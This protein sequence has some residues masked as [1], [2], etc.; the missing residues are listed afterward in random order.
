MADEPVN[1]YTKVPKH[2]LHEPENPNIELHQIKLPFRCCVVAP[3]GA[4]KTNWLINLVKLFCE[5]KGTFSSVF[6]LTRN[7]DEPLYNFLKSK[8]DS[9]Q[10][11]EG[12]HHLPPLDKFDKK[13][14]H[15]VVLDDLVLDDQKSVEKYYIRCRKLNVSIIFISQSYFRISKLIRS[16][17]SY[18]VI[19][20]LSGDRDCRL[21]LSEMSLGLSK[22]QLMA[23]YKHATAKKF[24]C[25]FIDCEAD[26][27]HRFRHNFLTVLDPSQ[28]ARET[29]G[30]KPKAALPAPAENVVL[31]IREHPAPPKSLR[32]K[33]EDI[34]SLR[35]ELLE[36]LTKN[37]LT[38]HHNAQQ[39]LSH[40]SD[41]EV[42]T[43]SQNLPRLDK[44]LRRRYSLGVPFEAFMEEVYQL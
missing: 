37:R 41:E 25:L 14:S 38:D 18:L 4:G 7:S 16:N 39:I 3:S 9:I 20:K 1:W 19:L 15:L 24:H 5:G 29:M 23:M 21:I 40:L 22:E 44:E 13:V 42:R 33:L 10:I 11:K 28:F 31:S 30:M 35:V 43:V 8:H 6:I 36:D 27:E 17:C 26:S 2:L 12:V 34:D 32:E